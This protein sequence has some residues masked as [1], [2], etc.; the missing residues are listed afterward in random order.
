M[1]PQLNSWLFVQSSPTTVCLT[2][3]CVAGDAGIVLRLFG[4]RCILRCHDLR[5]S[6]GRW[7]IRSRWC[8]SQTEET[9][10]AIEMASVTAQPRFCAQALACFALIVLLPRVRAAQTATFSDLGS[11]CYIDIGNNVQC[12]GPCVPAGYCPPRG[13]FVHITVGA[14][15]V[16]GIT[17][18]GTIAC[19][20]VDTE[21]SQP[22]V[23]PPGQFV[24]VQCSYDL[25][26]ALRASGSSVCFGSFSQY[27]AQ[28]PLSAQIAVGKTWVCILLHSGAI[29]CAGI[30]APLLVEVG[31]TYVLISAGYETLCGINGQG[32]ARC[33]CRLPCTAPSPQLADVV[34]GD[35]YACG[36]RMDSQ[37]IEC[38]GEVVPAAL[39]SNGMWSQ[40]SAGAVLY[41]AVSH[42]ESLTCTGLGKAPSGQFVGLAAGGGFA[43]GIRQADNALSCWGRFPTGWPH[44]AFRTVV[45]G[46][47]QC[48]AILL[49][50]S[51]TVCWGSNWSVHL[52]CALLT[53]VS[54]GL[55]SFPRATRFCRFR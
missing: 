14:A 3:R 55:L 19:S 21:T 38:F 6:Q 11:S 46:L 7:K 54:T 39:S 34:A 27:I 29:E 15:H 40:F 37:A 53:S 4:A 18:A 17:T 20:G 31:D 48:C 8:W 35:T 30:G 16:C 32:Y 49:A 51:S 5:L 36:I 44:A 24:D 28:L 42:D 47:A 45:C 50:N 1:L 12:F 9:I 23:V 43:C 13:Q 2:F 10:T 22:L 26:C 33:W 52:M 41:C 25:T